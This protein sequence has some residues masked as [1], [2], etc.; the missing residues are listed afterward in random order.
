MK[1]NM[2]T[3]SI[4]DKGEKIAARFLKK[5]GFRIIDRNKH[6]SKNE[7]D[8]VALNK[9]SVLFVEV[10]TRTVTENSISVLGSAA[11]AVNAKK[12]ERTIAAARDYIFESPKSI[13]DREIR[14]DV[15]EVYLDNIN[16]KLK[17]INHIENAFIVK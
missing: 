15:I 3:K 5:K 7:L 11:S 9:Q 14:F 4:G 16:F 2:T 6:Q 17:A 1:I 12:Q 8:I 10:K 13:K